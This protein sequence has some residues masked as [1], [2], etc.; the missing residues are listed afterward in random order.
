MAETSGVAQRAAGASRRT[1]AGPA[2]P[3]AGSPGSL[4]GRAAKGVNLLGLL[5]IVL[6][7]TIWELLIRTGLLAFEYIPLPSQI[8]AALQQLAAE[9]NLSFTVAHTLAAALVGWTGAALVGIAAGLLLGLV[10]ATWRYSMASVEVLRA[11]PIVAFVP[12][13]VLVFGFTSE[14]EIA[15]AFYAALWPVLVNTIAGV[16]GLDQRLIEVGRVLRLSTPAAILKLRLPAAVPSIVVGLRLGLGL[17][18]VLTIVVEMVGTPVGLGY[19]LIQAQQAL[20]PAQMFGYVVVI[21]VC[22][23]VLNAVLV[24][25]SRLLLRSTM[26]AAGDA[27]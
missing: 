12:V 18:L 26:A 3:G 22:G 23:I 21:G 15:V 25:A 4:L 7:L 6:L 13:V 8:A 27:A 19:A 17:S 9:G 1:G 5:T 14:A 11:L 24:G 20:R 10:P 16:R 2:R